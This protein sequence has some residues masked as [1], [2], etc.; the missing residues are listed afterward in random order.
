[1]DDTLVLSLLLL[2]AAI[3]G[4]LAA[5]WWLAERGRRAAAANWRNAEARYTSLLGLTPDGIITVGAD[6]R[7]ILINPQAEA[8]LGYGPGELLGRALDELLPEPHNERHASLRA[9]YLQAPE[10]R[11]MT[12]AHQLT[13]ARRKDGGL[14]PVRVSLNPVPTTTGWVVTAILHDLSLLKQTEARLRLQSVALESAANGIVITNRTGHILWTNPAFS[15]MTGYPADEVVG[16]T[17]GLLKSGR[18]SAEFYRAM[19]DTILAGQVWQGETVNRR[20]DG[21]LYVEEQT[22]APVRDEAGFVTHFVAIKQDVT[23]RQRAE[24]AVRQQAQHLAGLNQAMQALSSTLDLPEVLGRILGELR[25]LAPYDRA[26]ILLRQTEVL[27]VAAGQGFAEPVAGRSRPFQLDADHD[28]AARVVRTLAP[29]LLAE[30]EAQAAAWQ[31]ASAGLVRTWLGLPLAQGE[32]PLGLLALE[33]RAP[34]AFAAPQVQTALVFAAQAAIAIEN[35]RLY[36]AAQREVAERAR[37]ETELRDR[38]A[39]NIGLQQ[40]LQEQAIRDPLT[41]LFNRRYLSE[42]LERELA[43][44]SRAGLPLSVVLLDVDHFKRLNDTYGHKAGD[45]MLQALARLLQGN[46]RHEDIPCRYGGEEFVLVLM[47]APLAAAAQRA[48]AWRQTLEALTVEHE[49]WGLRATISLGVA[50]FPQ[51][52]TTTDELLK[53]ADRALYQAKARGRNQVAVAESRPTAPLVS[54]RE[55][56]SSE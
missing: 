10:P 5:A 37:A 35:A 51:H 2:S 26:A 17:P 14:V 54:Q 33:S 27:E 41:G 36:A 43:R 47:G 32:R 16:Q 52:G 29:V 9:T 11:P 49:A 3:G 12:G 8:L 46:S 21:S 45:L 48:E 22:I 4:G 50:A 1:M 56:T 23:R 6:G 42:T 31:G 38:L 53:A 13:A 24:A 20:K 18:H 7:I 44:A 40:R 25:L 30:A 34:E 15:R 55:R 19:W 39:E 28:P